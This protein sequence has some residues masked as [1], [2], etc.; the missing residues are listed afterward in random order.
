MANTLAVFGLFATWGH[1]PEEVRQY[2]LSTTTVTL[3]ML[4]MSPL[5]LNRLSRQSQLF[6]RPGAQRQS[7]VATIRV[8]QMV[9]MLAIL[10][11]IN[12]IVVLS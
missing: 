9:I 11:A 4:M 3:V 5:L 7:R 12:G 1:T 2:V 6:S 10:A 8:G